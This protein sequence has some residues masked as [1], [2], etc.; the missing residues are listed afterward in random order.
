LKINDVE[1]ITGLTAKAIRLYESRGLIDIPRDTNG[2]RNYSDNDIEALRL[3]G[4]LRSVGAS[5]S[6]IKL[7]LNGVISID[8]LVDKRKNEILKESGKN[9]KNY[10]VCEGLLCKKSVE[11]LF[12]AEGFA[13]KDEIKYDSY[14]ALTVGIDIGTTTVSAVIY[15]IDGKKQLEAYSVPHNS[16]TCSSIRY[17]Q[18][19]SVIIHKAKKLLDHILNSY[20]GIVGIGITGQMH[21]IVYVDDNGKAISNLINWQDKRA[22]QILKSGKSSCDEIFDITKEHISTGFGIATHYYNVKTNNVTENATGICSIMDLFAM[23]ICG[24]KKA[25]THTSVAASFGMFDVKKGEFMTDKLSLLGI[26][27]DILP[28]VTD[29][30]EIIGECR[31]IPVSVPIG[32]NQASFLGSVREN[33]SSILVNIGTGSQVSVATDYVEANGDIE[34]RP[35]IEGKYLLC[36]SALCGGYAYSMLEE[37]F[38]S[39]MVSAG[40][41]EVSQY[42]VLNQIASDEYYKGGEGLSVDVSFFGKRSDPDYRGSINNIDKQSFTPSALVLGVLNGMCRELYDLYKGFNCR[43]TD[44]IASGGAIKRNDLLKRLVADRF[45]MKVY[46]CSIDEEA[47]TGAALFSALSTGKIEYTNGFSDY[48]IYS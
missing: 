19:P 1:K 43:K 37:F 6:D 32:D 12:N 7:Y 13:E 11:E 26:N 14:G 2:Y 42:N 47:A 45:N 3:I 31:G 36:G 39:Y 18:D 22:D 28:S 15:D 30:S 21:G 46:L 25:L 16:Y 4:L 38:R 29:K 8:E 33:S 10:L 35:L 44:I 20:K 41:P 17:E 34:L 40:M 24:R 9:S 27:T 23:D 48:I 5:I